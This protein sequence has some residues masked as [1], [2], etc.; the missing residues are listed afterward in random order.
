MKNT[1]PSLGSPDHAADSISHTHAMRVRERTRPH[2]D[3]LHGHDSASPQMMANREFVGCD[4][5]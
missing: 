2:L 5:F 4:M 1:T 3:I